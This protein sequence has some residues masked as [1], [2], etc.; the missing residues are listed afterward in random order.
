MAPRKGPTGPRQTCCACCV[1]C[2]LHF[3]GTGAF[4]A[5]ID[6]K[7]HHDPFTAANLNLIPKRGRCEMHAADEWG[8]PLPAVDCT[9]WSLPS[10]WRGER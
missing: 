10:R 7:G 1:A 9:I 2:G 4:D 5:H 6:S 8:K 3:A